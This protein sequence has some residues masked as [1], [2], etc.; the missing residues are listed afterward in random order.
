MTERAVVTRTPGPRYDPDTGDTR[1]PAPVTVYSGP[2]KLRTVTA[3]EVS[4]EAAGHT[5]RQQRLRLDLPYGS[6]RLEVGDTAYVTGRAAPLVVAAID[7]GTHVTA[8]RYEVVR[9]EA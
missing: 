1:R 2:V 5:Y 6:P 3:Y 9:G 7:V 8:D 4:P